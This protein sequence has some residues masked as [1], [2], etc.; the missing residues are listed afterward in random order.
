MRKAKGIKTTSV[1]MKNKKLTKKEIALLKKK[2]KPK[3]MKEAKEHQK[4]VH[5]SREA[6]AE[7]YRA[8]L[9]M[10]K[11]E[12][13]AGW[14]KRVCIA[15]PTTG[16]VRIEWMMARFGQVIPCNWSNGD[17]FQYF[18]QYSPVGWAVAE[19]RNVCTEYFIS[20]GFEWLLFIDHDVCLPPDTFLRINEYMMQAEYPVVSGLYFCKGTHPEPLLFRGR[21]N[22]FFNNFRRG[23]KVMVDGIPMGLTL[24]HRDIMKYLYD[25]SPVETIQTIRGPVVVRKVF[26]TPRDSWYDPEEGKYAQRTGTEDLFWCD[27]VINEKVFEKC[28]NPK[29][30]KFGKLKNPF[31]CD[32]GMFARHIDDMGRMFP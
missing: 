13:W 18:D 32:T 15:V 9:E 31:L 28:G 24:I 17:I 26:E 16:L 2:G 11:S 19:A 6:I 22:G 3:S 8:K 21:G 20:Q 14:K 5:K 4:A 7:S 27:R 12:N 23:E 30:K 29:W 25:N 1:R 10:P